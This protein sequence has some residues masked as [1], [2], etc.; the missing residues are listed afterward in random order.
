MNKSYNSLGLMSGTSGDGID[1]S[2]IETDGKTQYKVLKNQF[3]EYPF[4]ITRQIHKLKEEIT[5]PNELLKHSED[6]ELIAEQ[7]TCLLYTSPSPRDR[8]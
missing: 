6:I 3:F 2:V 4:S 8:G 1:A 7:I 5:N